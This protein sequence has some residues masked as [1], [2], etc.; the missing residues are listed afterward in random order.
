MKIQIKGNKLRY[1]L[2]E[3]SLIH[4]QKVEYPVDPQHS[5]I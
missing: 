4:F 1:Q 2:L 3:I 5:K